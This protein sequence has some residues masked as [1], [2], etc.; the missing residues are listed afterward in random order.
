MRNTCQR[1]NERHFFPGSVEHLRR[2]WQS[3]VLMYEGNAAVGDITL[4]TFSA[5]THSL[6]SA[7]MGL[8]ISPD[9]ASDFS[10]YMM[11]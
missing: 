5:F 4:S 10:L 6:V 7:L 9:F 3:R 8:D 1:G 11:V 2:S